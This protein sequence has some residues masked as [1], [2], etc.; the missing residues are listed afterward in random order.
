MVSSEYDAVLFDFGGVLSDGPFEAFAEYESA[1]RLPAG[2]IRE[3]NA[4]DHHTNA[5]S[6]LERG[7]VSM[8]DFCDLFEAEANLAGGT[9]DARV[10][11][12]SLQG[13]IRPQMLEAVKRCHQHF[14]T[15]LLTN[16]YITVRGNENFEWLPEL[17]DVI[18][19]SAV[20][21]IR[22]PEPQFY[23]TACE[24]LGV[25]PSRSV[26]LD[27]LGVNLKPAR[28]LG[29]TTVKV[30]DPETALAE[31]EQLLDLSLK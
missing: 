21:G 12:G 8:E 7:E 20:E 27:D 4:K 14:K 23:L 3:L 15:G 26:F 24:R 22:K 2:F 13:K 31:L 25:E 19:E 28:A 30:G 11:I 6:Q 17:F 5:W 9:V 16:N 29:M 1:N 18:I 10:L